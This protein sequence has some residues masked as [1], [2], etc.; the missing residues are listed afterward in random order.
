ATLTEGFIGAL[1]AQ[2]LFG[3]GFAGIY[4]PGLK[5]MSDRIEDRLQS[6]AVALYT[7]LSGIGLAA[8]YAVA[9]WIG[10]AVGLRWAFAIAALGPLAAGGAVRV[11]ME[12]R[13]PPAVAERPGIVASFREVFRNKPALGYILG[14]AAHCWELYGLRAWMVAFLAFAAGGT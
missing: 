9:G 12:P 2:F 5:A 6:R 8:S 4:M 11:A 10:T 7:S 3:I 14:Y 1:V 13:E